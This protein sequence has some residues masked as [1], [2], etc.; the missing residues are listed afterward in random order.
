VKTLPHGALVAGAV[1]ALTLALAACD[2]GGSPNS[3]TAANS[4]IASTPP[5]TSSAAPTS[6]PTPAPTPPPTPVP[7]AVPTPSQA[8][9]ATWAEGVADIHIGVITTHD[10][11]AFYTSASTLVTASTAVAG[12]SALTGGAFSRAGTSGSLAV[13]TASRP[14][15]ATEVFTFAASAPAAGDPA[16]ALCEGSRLVAMTVVAPDAGESQG[17]S[18]DDGS[19]S[20]SSVTVLDSLT[21]GSASNLPVGCNGAPVVNAEGSVIGLIVAVENAVENS[22]VTV[23]AVPSADIVSW[24]SSIGYSPR[25]A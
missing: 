2:A 19:G 18:P 17:T 7:T 6:T 22:P 5:A 11:A 3:P 21:L 15:P 25:V 24:L 1:G 10:S 20:S 23:V 14:A 8:E 16:W 4:A 13:V 9:L 12:D